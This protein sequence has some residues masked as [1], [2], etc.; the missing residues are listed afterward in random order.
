MKVTGMTVW[1]S[2]PDNIQKLSTHSI[3]IE[4]KTY[5][6]DQYSNNNNDNNDINNTNRTQT[7]RH[8]SGQALTASTK[9][10]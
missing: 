9:S 3:K 1:N 6:I 8:K 7:L 5:L 2:V 10:A 4:F